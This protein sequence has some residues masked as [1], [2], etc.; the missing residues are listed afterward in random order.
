MIDEV[1]LLAGHELR[2]RRN[3]D[4]AGALEGAAFTEIRP[5]KSEICCCQRLNRNRRPTAP[6]GEAT[7]AVRGSTGRQA[8]S[9]SQPNTTR[10]RPLRPPHRLFFCVGLATEK[11]VTIDDQARI[12]T[13]SEFM[14]LMKG[15]FLG[16]GREIQ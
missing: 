3:A 9:P 7:L 6:E 1:P 16:W 2:L 8:S 14:G 12:A 13:T 5:G 11:P 10:A 15:L 4:W